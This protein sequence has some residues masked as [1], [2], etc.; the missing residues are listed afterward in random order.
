[1]N[2][3]VKRRYIDPVNRNIDIVLV[4]LAIVLSAAFLIL[5]YQY[6]QNEIGKVLFRKEEIKDI[7]WI[8]E[9]NDV[10]F[11]LTDDKINL[12]IDST[13]IIK[14][15]NYTLNS[16]TGEIT[17]E[18]TSDKLYIRAVSSNSLTIWYNY[19]EYHLEKEKSISSH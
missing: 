10:K 6:N 4:L 9:L 5:Y 1:M 17:I 19:A 7:T 16:Q 15:S 11:N 3:E 18:G 12:I 13:D 8:S 2:E 14:D